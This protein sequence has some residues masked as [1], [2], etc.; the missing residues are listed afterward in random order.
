MR[1]GEQTH[2]RTCKIR[3]EDHQRRGRGHRPRGATRPTIGRGHRPRGAT[4]PTIGRGLQGES[5]EATAINPP[6]QPTTAAAGD[7]D[8]SRRIGP[9]GLRPSRPMLWLRSRPL[10]VQNIKPIH[11]SEHLQTSRRPSCTPPV[12]RRSRCGSPREGARRSPRERRAGKQRSAV[13]VRR[14][15]DAPGRRGRRDQPCVAEPRRSTAATQVAEPGSS[16]ER[17]DRPTE[18][19]DAANHPASPR[20]R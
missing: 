13:G 10:D 12:R 6:R 17:P 1:R 16:T 14:G 2:P 7:A 20:H 4:R 5:D 18:R 11:E 9:S 3:K 15:R 8:R 19:V